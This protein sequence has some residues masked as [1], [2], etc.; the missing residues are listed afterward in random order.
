MLEIS[1]Q[2][3]VPPRSRSPDLTNENPFELEASAAERGCI[4]A[5][6]SVT[7]P[8]GCPIFH[9]SQS[10]R[11]ETGH[12]RAGGSN[13]TEGGGCVRGRAC[14]LGRCSAQRSDEHVPVGAELARRS[15]FAGLRRRRVR[16]SGC[17]EE[18]AEQ[19]CARGGSHVGSPLTYRTIRTGR[20]VGRA[21]SVQSV[22]VCG[23]R[24]VQRDRVGE[25]REAERVDW[26]SVTGWFKLRT[27]GVTV[28]PRQRPLFV[29]FV[30]L[31]PD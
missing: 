1:S 6:D 31:P 11:A 28:R 15:V 14:S 2:A 23:S 17:G 10:Y 21:P 30:V 16:C 27:A 12:G 5:V 20:S 8:S 13:S 18:E 29:L 25:W 19:E 26:E 9:Q 3:F 4:P 7:A 24:Q 22:E